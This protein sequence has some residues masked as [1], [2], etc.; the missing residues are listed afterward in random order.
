MDEKLSPKDTFDID[1][2]ALDPVIFPGNITVLA[3]CLEKL[4]IS[5]KLTE[6]NQNGGGRLMATM[7]VEHG[8]KV[9]WNEPLRAARE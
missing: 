8:G 4:A 2:S 1:L 6:H 7:N 9:R 5:A 3:K